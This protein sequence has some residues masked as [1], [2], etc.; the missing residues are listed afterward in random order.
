MKKILI[1]T[2]LVT[3]VSSIF[4]QE[5]ILISNEDGVPVGTIVTSLLKPYE[6][7]RSTNS[8][9][10][11]VPSNSSSRWAPA[12]GTI[13]IS[14]SKYYRITGKEVLPDLRGMFLRGL[15]SFDI[16]KTRKDGKEDPDGEKRK[17][18]S[19]QD[20]ALQGHHHSIRV[21]ASNTTRPE[22]GISSS[23]GNNTTGAVSNAV[24]EITTG[25]HGIPKV[26]VETRPK[27][28][29]VYYYIKI[30]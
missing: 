10:P 15:N 16:N 23:W 9:W 24:N 12:D 20:D 29:A 18:G 1:I 3:I 11:V 30:N 13:D 27:N 5:D 19:F 6:F 7:M 2:F 25:N 17:A 22:K 21:G 26:R 14:G 8:D 4:S 28:I